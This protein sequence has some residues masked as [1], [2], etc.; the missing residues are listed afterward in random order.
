MIAELWKAFRPSGRTIGRI[1]DGI[2]VYVVGDIHGRAD[3]LADLHARIER[4]ARQAS[5]GMRKI[6]IYIGDFVDRGP[7]SRQVIEMLLKSPPAGFETAF[8]RG[9][10]EDIMQSFLDDHAVGHD[11]LMF[12]GTDTIR[13]YGLRPPRS[14]SETEYKNLQRGFRIALPRRHREF[15]A[16]LQ[17]FTV[18]GNYVF[19]HAGIR[20]G[21]RLD[22]Q[23]PRD[24]MWIR[25]PFLRSR[26]DHG[27]IVVHGHTIVEAPEIRPNR[28]GIDTGAYGSNVLTCLVLEGERQEFLATVAPDLRREPVL[29][30][31]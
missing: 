26:K 17:L 14:A 23:T 7:Q 3:L 30:F 12:G 20:P 21:I 11:W 1:P 6:L 8:I 5:Q 25:E 2:R 16:G 22:Q 27:Y 10:H 28:I 9:N 24:L 19:V 4:H 29:S 15:L 31:R 18:I 13:S